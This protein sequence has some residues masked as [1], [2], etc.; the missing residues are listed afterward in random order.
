MYDRLEMVNL[1]IEGADHI[2]ASTIEFNLPQPSYTI[3]TLTHLGQRYPDKQ[4]ALIMGEDN[5]QNFEKWKNYEI[6]LRDYNLYV[7]PRPGYTAPAHLVEHPAINFT[8]TP[9]MEL[10]STFIRQA[11]KAGKNI[12]YF[13]ADKVVDFIEKK[14]LYR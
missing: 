8:Q 4:F 2:Q 9:H 11:I 10:S 14:G 3:D 13:T 12:Q 6:I 1:A 5:L 7:Y